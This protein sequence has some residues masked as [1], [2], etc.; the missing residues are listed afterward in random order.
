V[1]INFQNKPQSLILLNPTGR[2]N[3]NHPMTPLADTDPV[4][5]GI[6]EWVNAESQ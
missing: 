4:V 1:Q 6:T 3:P 5:L 2:A